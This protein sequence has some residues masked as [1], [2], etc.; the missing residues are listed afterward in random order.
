MNLFYPCHKKKNKKNEKKNKNPSQIYQKKVYYGLE[1]WHQDLT[2]K[3]KTRLNAIDGHPTFQGWS[4]TI[5]NI[6]EGECTIDLEFG[7]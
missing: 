6:L 1:I 3:I 7:T 2:H 5:Q 4:P